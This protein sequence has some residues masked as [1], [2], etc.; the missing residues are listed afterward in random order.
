MFSRRA[1]LKAAAAIPAVAFL[2]NRNGSSVVKHP[3]MGST[4]ESVHAITSLA[5]PIP[6]D[7]AVT[8]AYVD[9]LELEDGMCFL[10][11]GQSESRLNGDYKV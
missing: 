2:R 7:D 8:K 5:P 1:L 6:G 3:S 4:F 9:G 10:V 11:C